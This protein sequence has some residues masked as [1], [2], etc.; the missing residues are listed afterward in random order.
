MCHASDRPV[1]DFNVA[2]LFR[3]LDKSIALMV[4]TTSFDETRKYWCPLIGLFGPFCPPNFAF[5]ASAFS[6]T[7]GYIWMTL[8][9]QLFLRLSA[10]TNLFIWSNGRPSLSRKS[11]DRKPLPERKTEAPG[12]ELA[13]LL[14]GTV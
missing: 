2:D 4:S 14:T 7:A 10:R 6:V 11:S 9:A 13:N 3:M 5:S 12:V 1:F 8:N